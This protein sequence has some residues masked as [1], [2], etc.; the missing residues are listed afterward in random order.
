MLLDPDDLEEICHLANEADHLRREWEA[1]KAGQAYNA[2]LDSDCD[3]KLEKKFLK[4]I[5]KELDRDRE[6][7]KRFSTELVPEPVPETSNES[8]P[9]Q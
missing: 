9:D 7:N 5:Q 6:S 3:P 2:M 4:M 8:A 1:T